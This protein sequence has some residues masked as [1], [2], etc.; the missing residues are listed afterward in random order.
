[1]YLG[2]LSLTFIVS[3]FLAPC[4]ALR[5][6]SN[7]FVPDFVPLSLPPEVRRR[8]FP[9]LRITAVRTTY[10]PELSTVIFSS[11]ALR[12]TREG[13]PPVSIY[14]VTEPHHEPTGVPHGSAPRECPTG[15]PSE[16]KA[17]S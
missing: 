16:T 12:A 5:Y 2:I 4:A 3:Y 9:V 7:H 17:G 15:V 6:I 13:S 14:F 1:M 11:V 10:F 8:S